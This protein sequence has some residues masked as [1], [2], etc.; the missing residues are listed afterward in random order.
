MPSLHQGDLTSRPLTAS[1][2]GYA[3]WYRH[4]L[5]GKLVTL[6]AIPLPYISQMLN[7]IEYKFSQI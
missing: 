1:Q 4:Q 2:Q 3:P 7:K 6:R 5:S